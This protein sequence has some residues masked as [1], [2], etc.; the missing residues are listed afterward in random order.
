LWH[1]HQTTSRE[2]FERPLG[3][4]SSE[5]SDAPPTPGNDDLASVLHS[6]Q[7]LAEAIVQLTDP[8]LTRRLM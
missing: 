4:E 7:I 3:I 8:Y 6:L 5:A 2:V 1:P